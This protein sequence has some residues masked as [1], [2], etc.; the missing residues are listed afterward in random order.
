MS[1]RFKLI[2]P[3]NPRRVIAGILGSIAGASHDCGASVKPDGESLFESIDDYDRFDH[4]AAISE[5][6][7][8]QASLNEY[9]TS[10]LWPVKIEAS[11]SASNFIHLKTK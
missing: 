10:P 6:N 11:I 4:R 5:A 7:P 9:K 8:V 2:L 3:P 1:L